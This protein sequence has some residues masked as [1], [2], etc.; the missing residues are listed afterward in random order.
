MGGRNARTRAPDSPHWRSLPTPPSRAEPRALPRTKSGGDLPA[1]PPFRPLGLEGVPESPAA[2]AQ[3]PRRHLGRE[4]EHGASVDCVRGGGPSGER[5]RE[6]PAPVR[7]PPW[8]RAEGGWGSLPARTV[9]K[10]G[11]GGRAA[12][13]VALRNLAARCERAAR[14]FL[15]AR[16]GSLLP[17]SPLSAKGQSGSAPGLCP[18]P[19]RPYPLR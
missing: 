6:G 1:Q 3:S 4:K 11:P 10:A 16:S 17:P 15:P 14:A 7:G 19:P 2:P 18:P 13:S 5:G 9:W 8:S 12:P